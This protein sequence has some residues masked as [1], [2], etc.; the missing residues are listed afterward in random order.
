VR[1]SKVL[2]IFDIFTVMSRKSFFG[3]RGLQNRGQ[4]LRDPH[5]FTPGSAPDNAPRRAGPARVF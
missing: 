3:K 2:A 1:V 4:T 5:K